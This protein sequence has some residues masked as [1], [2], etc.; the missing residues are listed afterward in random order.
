[1]TVCA[2][3]GVHSA[4]STVLMN[5]TISLQQQGAS[6]DRL[7][8]FTPRTRRPATGYVLTATPVDALEATATALLQRARHVGDGLGQ[9]QHRGLHAFWRRHTHLEEHAAGCIYLRLSR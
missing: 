3:G 7:A 1:M 2:H 6:R 4:S 9:L 8:S 5:V